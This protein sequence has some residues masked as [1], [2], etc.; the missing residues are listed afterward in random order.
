MAKK[1]SR[2]SKKI[3]FSMRYRPTE[4][5]SLKEFLFCLRKGLPE[6]SSVWAGIR[7]EGGIRF[8]DAVVCTASR[9]YVRAIERV[10]RWERHGILGKIE[11]VRWPSPGMT[12]D[13]FLDASMV[14]DES[15]HVGSC[16]D[17]KSALKM[18]RLKQRK[19]TVR[20]RR[21]QGHKLDEKGNSSQFASA[22]S[23]SSPL[24]ATEHIDVGD[25]IK[26]L[27]RCAT[28]VSVSISVSV[29][30]TLSTAAVVQDMNTGDALDRKF[31]LYF[32]LLFVSNIFRL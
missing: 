32:L 22:Q 5:E 31:S 30:V 12:A 9:V 6:G 18:Y 25:D 14:S 7:I 1:S 27:E 2:T 15:D 23:K 21:T 11:H 26:P 4:S 19:R 24:P 20:R 10:E 16:E 29:S 17:V 3:V 8:I 28:E 13:S